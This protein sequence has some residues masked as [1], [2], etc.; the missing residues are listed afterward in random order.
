M[1]VSSLYTINSRLCLQSKKLYKKYKGLPYLDICIVCLA[2]FFVVEKDIIT[3][4]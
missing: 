4:Y 1:G 3:N 2:V